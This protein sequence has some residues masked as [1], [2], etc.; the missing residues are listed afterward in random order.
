MILWAAVHPISKVLSIS[1]PPVSL[2]FYR[3]LFSLFFFIPFFSLVER[4]QHQKTFG[5][6]RKW[7]LSSKHWKTLVATSILGIVFPLL[8]FSWGLRFSTASAASVLVNTTP[9]FIIAIT[10]LFMG[11]THSLKKLAGALVGFAGVVLVS[12]NG[13]LAFL[14]SGYFTGNILFLGEALFVAIAT[15]L[16]ESLSRNLGGFKTQYYTGIIALPLLF[17]IL[18]ATGE[19][20]SFASLGF[21]EWIGLLFVGIVF[22][23]FC[24]GFY[25]TS[26]PKVGAEN[27]A[28]M[29]LL[30]PVFAIAYSA[31]F[32]GEQITGP[33][34]TGTGLVLA[35]L[36]LALKDHGKQ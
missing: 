19:A 18:A 35:G 28:L 1:I 2:A 9:L 25:T 29:K 6:N 21:T 24:L 22:S 32:L 17:A 34:I 16:A 23:G 12:S 26:I 11:K 8:F 15:I 20:N 3:V 13:S 5:E 33:F 7:L 4:F 27:S 31:V 10:A 14:S 36:F 30:I